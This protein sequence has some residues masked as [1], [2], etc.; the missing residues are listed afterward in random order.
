MTKKELIERKKEIDV[1][2]FKAG[3]YIETREKNELDEAFTRV[4]YYC[5]C[6]NNTDEQ[7]TVGF[8]RVNINHTCS[9]CGNKYFSSYNESSVKMGAFYIKDV[10]T[11][12]INASRINFSAKVVDEKFKVLRLNMIRDAEIDLLESKMIFHKNNELEYSRIGK[13]QEALDYGQCQLSTINAFFKQ[14]MPGKKLFILDILD[15]A[16]NL[17]DF[18]FE[19]I[20]KAKNFYSAFYNLPNLRSYSRGYV[21]PK[22]SPLYN[23][24]NTMSGKLEPFALLEKLINAGIKV[25]SVRNIISREYSYQYTYG[26]LRYYY[27]ISDR[28]NVIDMNKK[29]LH[30]IL[31]CPRGF[32]NILRDNDIDLDGNVLSSME[33]MFCRGKS[34]KDKSMEFLKVA[35]ENNVLDSVMRNITSLMN[36]AESYN[37]DYETLINY[38]FVSCPMYQGLTSIAEVLGLLTDYLDMSVKMGF[39]YDK[40]PDSLK[41]A[42]D[43]KM[44]NY[45]VFKGEKDGQDF[46][47]SV[48]QY[49]DL[50]YVGQKY[51]IVVPR[52]EQDL[53]REG[54]ML[55]HC[56]ASYKDRVIR[57]RSK[58]LFMRNIED[59]SE[60]LVSIELNNNY[61]LV[62]SRGV[63]N[64]A[65]RKEE[66][67]FIQEW[68]E[69]VYDTLT[70]RRKIDKKS[71]IESFN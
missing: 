33:S 37:F 52:N 36:L 64:R 39:K 1:S 17:N 55:H 58:I 46:I 21:E 56:I 13:E 48:R 8:T 3:L 30:Q 45:R 62:Q 25:A 7:V 44:V 19:D 34:L 71:E 10:R 4:K 22:Y 15:R 41:R 68:L 16:S 6:G 49:S 14:D 60:P 66:K 5:N 2:K 24:Y 12:Y 51:Q 18:D 54:S 40:Y 61:N 26:G 20:E 32:L 28:Y 70:K 50:I 31:S 29:K 57:G 42:H 27:D 35:I 43:V 38:V 11:S 47:N 65:L 69:F 63:Y 23:L 59:V 67:D 53:V 9:E